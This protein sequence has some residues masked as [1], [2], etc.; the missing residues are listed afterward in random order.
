MLNIEVFAG[1][2]M[3]LTM[4]V[5]SLLQVPVPH[6]PPAP[7]FVPLPS[8]AYREYSFRPLFVCVCVC[9]CVCVGGL[10]SQVTVHAWRV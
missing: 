10:R 3:K 2:L 9:V 7:R 6:P 8:L 4:Q 1:G 5:N